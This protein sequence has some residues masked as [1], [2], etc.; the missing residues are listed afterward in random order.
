MVRRFALRLAL[1][2]DVL[3][4]RVLDGC[5]LGTLVLVGWIFSQSFLPSPRATVYSAE[6]LPVILPRSGFFPVEQLAGSAYPYRWTEGEASMELAN[7]GGNL[8][9]RIELGG[10]PERTIPA[11]LQSSGY[12]VSFL[13]TPAPR[14]YLVLFP[15]SPS[16]RF[17]LHLSAP[18]FL[19]ATDDPEEPA[20][21][22]AL[23]VG[24]VLVS[25]GGNMPEQLAKLLGLATIVGYLLLRRCDERQ[26]RPLLW[27]S[28]ILVLQTILLG[29]Y[30]FGGW[31]FGL[32]GSALWLMIGVSVGAII[33]EAMIKRIH[34]GE[35]GT[36]PISPIGPVQRV[37]MR[38]IFLILLLM[39]VVRIPFLTAPDPVGDLELAARR[40]WYL[41][42]EGL[43]G[44]Y[45]FGGDYMPL[46]I[47]LLSL[48]SH[49]VVRAGATDFHE[50][51]TPVVLVC[52][53]LPALLADL[54]TITMVYLWSLRWQE[55]ARAAF[56]AM[57]YGLAPPVWINV[58]WWGQ[59]DALLMLPM[60]G[61][62]A[63]L[64]QNQGIWSWL[65]WA[66]ALLIKPQALVIAPLLYGA[67]LRL[68]G[69][70]GFVLGAGG[71]TGV[72]ILLSIPLIL[73][74]QGAGLMQAYFGSIG[75]FPKLTI[76]A[77]NLWYLLTA[78]EGGDDTIRVAGIVSYRQIGLVLVAGVGGLV[79]VLACLRADSETRMGSGAVLAL[80]FFLLPTQ[81]HERYLFLCL[82][83]VILWVAT[84]PVSRPDRLILFLTLITTATLNILGTL[85][86]FMPVV[87]AWIQRLSW[88]PFG[89]AV[90]NLITL[91]MLV[92]QVIIHVGPSRI[93]HLVAHSTSP[94]DAA[95]R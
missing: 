1:D 35:S 54:S 38:S 59:V 37:S 41:K 43:A 95:H 78:G 20:R 75:R 94:R 15:P 17:T 55:P 62:L 11:A 57:L 19:E 80:A 82:A 29:W 26:A 14:H 76:G 7:P 69:I 22:L 34:G 23:M 33:L 36:Y 73:A 10:G 64:E 58:A 86:H 24:D 9:I 81:I 4:T 72:F 56:L 87:Y 67:T 68:H 90:L 28:V 53:K 12:R 31:A 83:F 8:F 39:I 5:V 88:L 18:T 6:A 45:Q 30:G 70:R 27:G 40:M 79:T 51:L 66:L 77:Y 63:L 13:V 89:C 42:Q 61:S 32:L 85:D 60:V 47:Y 25:G 3:G 49:V 50:R 92:V 52:I 84:C 74:D 93:C 2:R 48:L 16:E 21:W 65:C 46:R 44:A 91:G 71:A